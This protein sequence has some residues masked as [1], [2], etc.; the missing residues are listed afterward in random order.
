MNIIATQI[1]LNPLFLMELVGTPQNYRKPRLLLL[2]NHHQ[3]N[4]PRVVILQVQALAALVVEQNLSNHHK[5]II[6][7]IKSQGK[8]IKPTI[9]QRQDDEV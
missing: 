2:Q 9:C 5:D 3:V 4:H 8:I 6:G 7:Y 1:Q